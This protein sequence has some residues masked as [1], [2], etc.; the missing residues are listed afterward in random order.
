M[1]AA[2]RPVHSALYTG[3]VRH[4]RFGPRRHRFQYR[5]FMAY[6]DLAELPWLFRGTPLW[7]TRPA[8][9]WFR[10]RDYLG[11][12][13]VPLDEAVRD[14]VVEQTGERPDGAIRLL[15]NLRY[16]GFL[17]NP[18]SC[19]YC[20]DRRERLRWIVAEVTNTPWKERMP[21]VIPCDPE[22]RV[23]RHRFDKALHVSPFM[24]MDMQYAW[25][26]TT[27]G[28]RLTLHL[29]NL[30][31]GREEFNATLRL[32]RRPAT[33]G[34]LNR[35]LLSYP[36]MTMKVGLGIYWQA[37]RLF[38]KRVPLHRHPPRNNRPDQ[39]PD[40]HRFQEDSTR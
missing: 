27:P 2:E 13:H 23:Q 7:S 35:Q 26:G 9:A 21:Y 32:E 38:L 10:R 16:F 3:L 33:A 24:P 14:C 34:N 19:Y 37:L 5:V 6:I 40:R 20:F 8:P 1:T 39:D 15:T 28:E 30:R 25:R 22:A 29:K 12:P 11:E 4:Q 31:R 36:W 18:I 17:M